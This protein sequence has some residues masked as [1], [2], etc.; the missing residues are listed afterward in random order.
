MPTVT[1]PTTDRSPDEYSASYAPCLP[2]GSTTSIHNYFTTN[3]NAVGQQQFMNQIFQ[4]LCHCAYYNSVDSNVPKPKYA[5]HLPWLAGVF[6]HCTAVTNE[7]NSEQLRWLLTYLTDH[8]DQTSRH[9]TPSF[10]MYETRTI[11]RANGFPIPP[12]SLSS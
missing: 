6:K 8:T 1:I 7:T 3:L 2:F 12:L 4:E 10:S 9:Y 11:E 5:D